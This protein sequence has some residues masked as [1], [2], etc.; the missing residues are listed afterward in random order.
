MVGAALMVS[1]PTR[2]TPH[3]TTGRVADWKDERPGYRTQ[4]KE[5]T[6]GF[7]LIVF[8]TVTRNA[9]KSF[10]SRLTPERAIQKCV[11]RLQDGVLI[12]A[13]LGLQ[14]AGPNKC[15]DL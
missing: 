15:I 11:Q 7:P 2:R 6:L 12:P 5:H 13:H 1:V 10:A 9:S 4:R 3:A 8:I 14:Q